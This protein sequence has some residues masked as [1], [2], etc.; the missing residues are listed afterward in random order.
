LGASGEFIEIAEVVL[1]H[2]ERWDGLGYPRGLKGEDISLNA[3]II[4]IADTYDAMVS[5]R[6][7]RHSYSKKQAIEE[8]QRCAGTQFDPHLVKLF[9]EMMDEEPIHIEEINLKE[10]K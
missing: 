9:T 3:R 2:H 5:E 4:A 6:A 1:Q 10:L 8:I 7:Y